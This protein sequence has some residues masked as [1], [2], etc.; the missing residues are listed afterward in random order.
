M[1]TIYHLPFTASVIVGAIDRRVQFVWLTAG[2]GRSEAEL[3]LVATMPSQGPE[4]QTLRG[5]NQGILN[6]SEAGRHS[7]Q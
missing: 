4:Q 1:N 3:V 7:A 2:E 5:N 6:I